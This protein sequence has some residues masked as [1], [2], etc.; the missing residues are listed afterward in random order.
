MGIGPTRFIKPWP[1]SVWNGI[2]LGLDKKFQLPYLDS[3]LHIMSELDGRTLNVGIN[4]LMDSGLSLALAAGDLTSEATGNKYYIG[5][6]FTNG[7]MIKKI[8]QGI[9]LAKRAVKIATE[10]DSNTD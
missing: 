6:N 1:G 7:S 2:F 9:E 5:I 8:A 10:T 3:Q 4:Y